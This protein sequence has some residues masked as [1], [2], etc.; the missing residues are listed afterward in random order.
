MKSTLRVGEI[1]LRNVKSA[2]RRVKY[3]CGILRNEFYFISCEH[4]F[5]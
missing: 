5:L 3:A 2:Y 4:I 1:L